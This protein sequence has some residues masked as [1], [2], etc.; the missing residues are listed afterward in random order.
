MGSTGDDTAPAAP[1]SDA[2]AERLAGLRTRAGSPSFGEIAARVGRLRSARPEDAGRPGRTTVYDAFRPGRRR[3]DAGLILDIATVLGATDRDLQELAALSGEA[4]APVRTGALLRAGTGPR[5]LRLIGREDA[6]AAVLEGA[7]RGPVVV[8]GLGGIGKTALVL[9]AAESLRSAGGLAPTVVIELRGHDPSHAPVDADTAATALLTALGVG[10]VPTGAVERRRMLETRLRAEPRVVVLDNVADTAQ[11][12]ALLPR[13]LP[14]L[15]GS[16][17]LLTA[18]QDL[19]G[20]PV[21]PVARVALPP[22][23]G[24]AAHALF[25]RLVG[26]DVAATDPAAATA[27]VDSAEGIPLALH[28]VGARVATRPEWT[29]RDHADLQRERRRERLAEDP[30]T[31]IVGAAYHRLGPAAR[32]ALRR[33]ADQPCAA[34][35]LASWAASVDLE[36]A[37]LEPLVAELRRHH[38]VVP[39]RGGEHGPVRYGL[40]DVVRTHVV[41]A[42]REED[43]PRVREEALDRLCA[44]LVGRV[45]ACSAV[46]A[47]ATDPWYPR[48]DTVAPQP[49][50][51]PREAAGWLEATTPDV[52]ALARAVA[53]TRPRTLIDLADGL[54]PWL[55]GQWRLVEGQHLHGLAVQAAETLGDRGALARA[56]H[57]RGSLFVWLQRSVESR[58]HLELALRAYRDLGLPPE[59]ELAVL[60]SLSL[61]ERFSGRMADALTHTREA[62]ALLPEEAVAPRIDR[63]WTE[64]HCLRILGREAEARARIAAIEADAAVLLAEPQPRMWHLLYGAEELIADGEHARALADLDRAEEALALLPAEDEMPAYPAVLRA[65]ALAGL[66]RPQEAL[67]LIAASVP[68]SEAQGDLQLVVLAHTYAALAHRAQGDAEQAVGSAV[69]AR[70]LA[71]ELDNPMATAEAWQVLGELALDAGDPE[72]AVTAWHAAAELWERVGA[73]RAAHWRTRAEDLTRSAGPPGPG[74]RSSRR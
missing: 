23:S 54:H 39:L 2:V 27:L 26:T 67:D 28:L 34:L 14:T 7:P 31:E 12:A 53:E 71:I 65:G 3:P 45:W 32:W 38:L 25:A 40:H 13:A 29:L 43:P 8:H 70:D 72:T 33:L 52:L 58:G 17:V 24:A 66:G 62:L 16:A 6:L 56:R 73:P 61:V 50:P 4:A 15:R 64:I 10:V 35:D 74:R 41:A 20:L 1:A 68:R 55:H 47:L 11:V 46:A 48:P 63:W 30:L 19:P 37:D 9:A 44:H 49:S 21:A 51:A 59:A 22:L 60:G 42:A 5:D 18:R 36:P 69:A 57:H